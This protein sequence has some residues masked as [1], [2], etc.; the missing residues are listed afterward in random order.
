VTV[1]SER[2]RNVYTLL[3]TYIYTYLLTYLLQG[4]NLE[5]RTLNFLQKLNARHTSVMNRLM[6]FSLTASKE[7]ELLCKNYSVT[8]P[9]A[10][11]RFRACVWQALF[12]HLAD[13]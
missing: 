1:V 4:H 11:G 9:Q 7:F 3:H 13:F 12:C 2:L 5:M 10:H 6:L 8:Q